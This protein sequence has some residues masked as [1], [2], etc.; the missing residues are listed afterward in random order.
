MK[1]TRAMKATSMAA[2]FR[3]S[4][5]PSE[6]PAAAASTTS[7][8]SC[9][10]GQLDVAGGLRML[11]LRIKQLGQHHGGRRRH[12]AG[13]DQVARVDAHLHVAG[14]N[15]AGNGGEAADHHRV[16]LVGVMLIIRN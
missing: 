1:A 6:A 14:Q 7:S 15:A 3:A 13:A 11:G 5:R 10:V 9:D 16:Q 12:H 8:D 2:T 4:L